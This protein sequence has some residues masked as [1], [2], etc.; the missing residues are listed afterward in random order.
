VLLKVRGELH[1]AKSQNKENQEKASEDHAKLQAML[2]AMREEMRAM[3]ERLAKAEEIRRILGKEIRELEIERKMILGQR[4]LAHM[5][6]E[7]F[8]LRVVLDVQRRESLQTQEEETRKLEKQAFECEIQRLMTELDD[9]RQR[10]DFDLKE[11]KKNKT[12]GG[13]RRRSSGSGSIGSLHDTKRRHSKESAGGDSPGGM[14][15]DSNHSV[16]VGAA[17]DGFVRV[18][19]TR[20]SFSHLPR[21]SS[22]QIA[23]HRRLSSANSMRRGSSRG[24]VTG[25][26]L[27]QPSHES[28]HSASA[29]RKNSHNGIIADQ[30]ISD[31]QRGAQGNQVTCASIFFTMR[32]SFIH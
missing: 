5:R 3:E 12:R 18:S 25:V 7:D 15:V 21:Q 22:A 10:H 23:K 26:E 14:G 20:Q 6:Y 11:S 13:L 4:E 27:A 28:R 24:S 16:A 8:Y 29:S 31:E 1:D 32:S 2:D 17:N 19:S 30:E 9:E